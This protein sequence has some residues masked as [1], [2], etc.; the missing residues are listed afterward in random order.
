M[1]ISNFDLGKCMYL[2]HVRG[3]QSLHLYDFI[4]TSAIIKRIT[5]LGEVFQYVLLVEY[6]YPC[7]IIP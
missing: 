5:F 2:L 4:V 1:F 6:R 3:V 7:A